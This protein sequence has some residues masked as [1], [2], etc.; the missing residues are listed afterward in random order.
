LKHDA[1]ATGVGTAPLE[2]L[3]APLAGVANQRLNAHFRYLQVDLP[4]R[5]RLP[6]EVRPCKTAPINL[7]RDFNG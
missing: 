4:R 5:L 2:R 7:P 1:V 3:E 6:D